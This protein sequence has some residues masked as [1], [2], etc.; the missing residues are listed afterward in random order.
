MTKCNFCPYAKPTG[1][2]EGWECLAGGNSNTCRQALQAMMR[3]AE[4]M[5]NGSKKIC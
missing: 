3:Y 2:T 1:Q 5:A 4:L